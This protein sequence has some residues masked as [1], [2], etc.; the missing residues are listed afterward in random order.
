MVDQHW[1]VA[2]NNCSTWCWADGLTSFFFFIPPLLIPLS[3]WRTWTDGACLDPS[4][5][6]RSRRTH[7]Q[8]WGHAAEL[9]LCLRASSSSALRLLIICHDGSQPH[10]ALRHPA[11]LPH[12]PSHPLLPLPKGG[13]PAVG[14]RAGAPT[15]TGPAEPA[16]DQT[17]PDLL[18]VS[19]KQMKWNSAG[20]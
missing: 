5:V 9:Q 13:E 10:V 12:H 20:V 8:S 7:G 19:L 4:W 3:S 2:E 14:G 11:A 18:S 15:S 1:F 6:S 17:H 16:A